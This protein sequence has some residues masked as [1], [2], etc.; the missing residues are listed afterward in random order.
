MLRAFRKPVIMRPI[1]PES[2]KVSTRSLFAR[3]V[4]PSTE[5]HEV[6]TKALTPSP[7]P[8]APNHRS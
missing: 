3:V 6:E 1:S 7:K 4:Q 5:K 2:F 8:L